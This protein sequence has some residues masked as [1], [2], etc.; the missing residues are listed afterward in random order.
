MLRYTYT[1][2][3]VNVI[4]G[5]TYCKHCNLMVYVLTWIHVTF[6]S[7]HTEK[8]PHASFFVLIALYRSKIS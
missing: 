1:A 5:V 2:C 8:I 4:A 6:Y 3:L 7:R